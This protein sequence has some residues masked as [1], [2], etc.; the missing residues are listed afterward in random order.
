MTFVCRLI[1]LIFGKATANPLAPPLGGWANRQFVG[2]LNHCPRSGRSIFWAWP[3]CRL[4]R[5]RVVG[6]DWRRRL[7]FSGCDRRWRQGIIR[8]RPDNGPRF[9]NGDGDGALDGAVHTYILPGET[10]KRQRFFYKNFTEIP[11]NG[12]VAVS[13]LY[14][15]EESE[16]RLTPVV[17]A[18]AIRA[19]DLR[20]G[21]DMLF[22]IRLKE[23]AFGTRLHIRVV[24]LL[25]FGDTMAIELK[26]HEG[27]NH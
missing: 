23:I 5:Q 21:D 13:S 9:R 27:P 25:V 19:G 1:L 7:R 3:L 4:V 18:F 15:V 16:L 14:M 8:V 2:R 20:L 24:R 17:I 11:Q 26:Q 22:L 6:I 12:T 10:A